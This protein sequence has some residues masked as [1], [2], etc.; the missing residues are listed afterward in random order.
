[1]L[2]GAPHSNTEAQERMSRQLFVARSLSS[3]WTKRL[4]VFIKKHLPVLLS[5]KTIK[6]SPTRHHMMLKMFRTIH[7]LF[8]LWVPQASPETSDWLQLDRRSGC[9]RA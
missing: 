8:V 5:Y 1:M 7:L 9:G 4:N 3:A 6:A 2:P